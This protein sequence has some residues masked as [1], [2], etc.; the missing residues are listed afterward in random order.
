MSSGQSIVGTA[1]DLGMAT[2]VLHRWK[3]DL[4]SARVAGVGWT[5]STKSNRHLVMQALT[6]ALMHRELGAQRSHHSG[7]GSQYASYDFRQRLDEHA[8]VCSM[9]GTGKA[10]DRSQIH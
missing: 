7:K 3:R 1:K 4:A 9:S 8:S 5:M 6:T 10:Y 2:S